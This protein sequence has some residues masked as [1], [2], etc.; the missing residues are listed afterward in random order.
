[1]P[2]KYSVTQLLRVFRVLNNNKNG[3]VFNINFNSCSTSY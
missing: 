3:K 1:M 2:K